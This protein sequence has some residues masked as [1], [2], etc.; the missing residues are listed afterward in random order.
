RPTIEV[1]GVAADQSENVLYLLDQSMQN[2]DISAVD[3][4]VYPYIRLRMRNLDSVNLSPYQLKYWRIFY[5]PVP[6]GAIAPNL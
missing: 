4:S 3:A 5:E 2:F 1:I 6:E